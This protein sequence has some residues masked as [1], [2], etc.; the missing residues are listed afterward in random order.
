MEL[1]EWGPNAWKFLHAVTFAYPE[2]PSIRMQQ[3]AKTFFESLGDMLPCKKC[4]F[5]WKQQLQQHP[6][7]TK[8]REALSRWLVMAHNQVNASNNKRQFSYDE[9]CDIYDPDCNRCIQK[10]GV[11]WIVYVVAAVLVGVIIMYKIR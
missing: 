2:T 11:P 10:E 6:V 4:G 3:K 1:N 8:N 7:A 9:V 5:H